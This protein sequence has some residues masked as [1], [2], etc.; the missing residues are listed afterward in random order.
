[1]GSVE[2]CVK[3]W[4]VLRVYEGWAVCVEGWTVFKDV[5]RARQCVLKNVLRAGQHCRVC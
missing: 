3:G 2:G 5:L 4:A 1:M